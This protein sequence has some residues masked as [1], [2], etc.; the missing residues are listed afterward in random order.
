MH[1]GVQQQLPVYLLAMTRMPE[2][3]AHFKVEKIS[4]AGCFLLPLSGKQP[5]KKSRREALEDPDAAKREGYAHEGLFD[6]KHVNLFDAN[7]PDEKSG[8]FKYRLTSAGVPWG[9]TFN[10][11]RSEEFA[12]ILERSAE[13]IREI[14]ERVYQGDIAIKPYKHGTQTPCTWCDYQ[15]VCRF[16]AWSQKFNVLRKPEKELKP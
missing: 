6:V 11:L 2:V 8:Q 7:A 1:H 10:A 15:P 4:A 9:G 16:D 12:A 14:G 13:L 3:A 5:A